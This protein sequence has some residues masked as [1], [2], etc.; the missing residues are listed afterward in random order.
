M[1]WEV[2]KLY[3]I[4]RLEVH[5]SFSASVSSFGSCIN[6]VIWFVDVVIDCGIIMNNNSS[7]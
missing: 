4:K 3:K 1:K 7:T 5:I 6:L 2:P